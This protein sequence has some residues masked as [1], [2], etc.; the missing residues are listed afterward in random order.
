MRVK[1]ALVAGG[2]VLLIICAAVGWYMYSKPH[3]GVANI[4]ADIRITAANLYSDFQRNET[5]ANKKY[6]NKV[7]EVTGNVSEVQNV[8]GSQIIL[9]SSAGD[10]GGVSCQ[11]TNDK[12]N[13]SITIKKS[14]TVTVKGK[15]SG[16]LI[17]VNLVDC[18]LK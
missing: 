12:N 2:V 1:L 18:V 13:T 16:Y 15:C 9:L 8:N 5:T 11:L 6:L 3:E 7:I 4:E 10:M 14:L 17:D